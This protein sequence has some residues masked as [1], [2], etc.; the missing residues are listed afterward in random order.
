MFSLK[1]L[2]ISLFA[3]AVMMFGLLLSDWVFKTEL[4]S[5]VMALTYLEHLYAGYLFGVDL[6]KGFT[7]G[8]IPLPGN[9][10]FLLATAI[11]DYLL[12]AFAVYV[13][14]TVFTTQ[15]SS[16]RKLL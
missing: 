2:L 11:F 12:V 13:L 5:T 16:A 8:C 9:P 7:G 14:L 4:V 10:L 3:P 15:I 1:N 6:E